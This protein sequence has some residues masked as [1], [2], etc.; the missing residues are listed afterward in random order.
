MTCIRNCGALRS[1]Q[2]TCV[3]H[4]ATLKGSGITVARGAERCLDLK[5]RDA[6]TEKEFAV[7]M[8]PQWLGLQC[9]GLHRIRPIKIPAWMGEGAGGGRHESTLSQEDTGSGWQLERECQ[10]SSGMPRALFYFC[11][12][13]FKNST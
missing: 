6:P 10:F 12:W 4:S 11:F 2:D 5:I 1:K 13:L 3:T 8:N 7:H 9:K